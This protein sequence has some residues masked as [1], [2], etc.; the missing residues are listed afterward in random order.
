MGAGWSGE[1]ITLLPSSVVCSLSGVSAVLSYELDYSCNPYTSHTHTHVCTSRLQAGQLEKLHS[2]EF[3]SLVRL[4]ERFVVDTADITGRQCPSLRA[5]LLSHVSLPHYGMP[6]PHFH[7]YILN[8]LL[9]PNSILTHQITSHSN[10]TSN[11]QSK[12]F[13]EQF[14]DTRKSKLGYA[15]SCTTSTVCSLC[16]VSNQ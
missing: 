6:H 2:N 7:S 10:F 8:L 15:H 4:I 9:I 14:H 1:G 13:L 3:T 11:F 16:N 12:K 5:P